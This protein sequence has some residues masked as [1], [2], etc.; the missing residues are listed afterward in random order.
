M[1]KNFGKIAML[2]VLVL[3]TFSCKKKKKLNKLLETAACPVIALIEPDGTSWRDFEYVGKQ[4]TRIYFN[5]D[6]RMVLSIRYGEDQ[7][8]KTL[9]IDN[10]VDLE[11]VVV[12]YTYDEDGQISETNSSISGLPFMHNVFTW[13]D[14]KVVSVK[15]TVELFGRSVDGQTRIEYTGNNV[16]A[17]YQSIDSDP[18]KMVYQG[19][20]YD[21]KPL[22]MPGVF[23]QVCLGFVGIANN[24]FSYMG[25]N[26]MV[27]GKLYNDEGK[28]DQTTQIIF[29]YDKKDLIMSGEYIIEQNGEI[30]SS[31]LRYEYD[32]N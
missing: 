4:L 22:F 9:E 14:N 29:D 20:K 32:C 11:K 8:I 26:N 23:R 7:R 1:L 17:V 2:G 31:T 21:D 13:Q 25:K 15:T 3:L 12:S 10:E 6:T 24:F 28:V 18:E 27:I 19:E 5:D 30:T 16:R